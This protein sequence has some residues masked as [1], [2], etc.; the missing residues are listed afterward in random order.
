MTR[1][2]S[3][4]RICHLPPGSEEK[5]FLQPLQTISKEMKN[6]DLERYYIEITSQYDQIQKS[7]P[8]GHKKRLPFLTDNF[9]TDKTSYGKR[10]IK[11]QALI[12]SYVFKKTND[13]Q[14]GHL[15]ILFFKKLKSKKNAPFIG[16]WKLLKTWIN[17]LDNWGHC[18]MVCG[19]YSCMLEE[20]PNEV[21]PSL[22]TWAN[23]DDP[24]KKRTAIVSLLYYYRCRKKVLHFGK[25]ISLVEPQ[26]EIDHYYLQ[27]AVGWTLRELHNAYPKETWEFLKENVY[28]LR[29][30]VFSTSMEKISSPRKN[31]LKRLRKI[32]RKKKNTT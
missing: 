2:G 16:Y 20:A 15:P 5:D 31:E 4:V 27:K 21:Y 19:L 25:M 28:R 1:K 26:L 29:P 8:R 13:H 14:I 10:P 23:S 7:I 6:R 32:N 3:A 24:W 12:W 11:E 17:K 9:F 22:K 30:I 18:D